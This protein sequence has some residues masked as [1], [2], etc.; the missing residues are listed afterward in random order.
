MSN[1]KRKLFGGRLTSQRASVTTKPGQDE[2]PP[3]YTSAPDGDISIDDL[4]DLA[5]KRMKLLQEINKVCGYQ[6]PLGGCAKQLTSA[7]AVTRFERLDLLTRP[8]GELDHQPR[9]REVAVRDDSISHNLLRL[10]LCR[11]QENKAWLVRNEERLF[12]HRLVRFQEMASPSRVKQFMED[13]GLVKGGDVLDATSENKFLYAELRDMTPDEH[14]DGRQAVFYGLPFKDVPPHLIATR[15]VLVRKGIAY[16]PEE[17][18][19]FVACRKYR[20]HLEHALDR[21]VPCAVR[22][23]ADPRLGSL[24]ASMGSLSWTD[25]AISVDVS[26]EEKLTLANWQIYSK[27]SFPPCMAAL[28]DQMFVKRKHLKYK[29]RC[30]LQPFVKSA[31]FSLEDSRVW[32]RQAMTQDGTV[33]GSKFDKEYMYGINYTYGKCGNMK[34]KP[35]FKC[36]TVIHQSYPSGEESHGC[37]FRHYDQ[38]NLAGMLRAYNIDADKQKEILTM[39][40]DGHHQ[41]GCRGLFTALHP[42]NEGDEM[43]NHPMQYYQES[44]RYWAAKEKEQRPKPEEKDAKAEPETQPSATVEVA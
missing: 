31:G 17:E 15:K 25:A 42:G 20:S 27:R 23:E 36:E 32:W 34:E 14:G 16:M 22:A 44:V 7:D 30:Q 4:K 6:T 9:K 18:L 39:A 5:S 35:C 29:G 38:E 28:V 2:P 33:D 3:L 12:L 8:V 19:K 10:A 24:L 1:Q 11:T 21:A 43:G 13:Q 37:P 40:R 26:D 41:M